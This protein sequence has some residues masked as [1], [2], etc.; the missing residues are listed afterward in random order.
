MT[1][2]NMPRF[3][4]WETKKLK[5]ADFVAAAEELEPGYQLRCF[6]CYVV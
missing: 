3:D 2:R 4:D 5:N 6:A 1:R